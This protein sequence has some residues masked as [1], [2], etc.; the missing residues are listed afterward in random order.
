MFIIRRVFPID[1]FVQEKGKGPK[2]PRD[3]NTP[4]EEN[5]FQIRT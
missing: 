5:K 4:Q 3:L 1:F 2:T